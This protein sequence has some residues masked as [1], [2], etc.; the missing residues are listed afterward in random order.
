MLI[1]RYKYRAVILEYNHAFHSQTYTIGDIVYLSQ[2]SDIASSSLTD[3]PNPS[4]ADDV[5]RD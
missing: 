4:H 1:V 3:P 2:A 5:G